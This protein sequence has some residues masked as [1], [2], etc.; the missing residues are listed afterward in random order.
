MKETSTTT[1]KYWDF[2]LVNRVNQLFSHEHF[3]ALR[4]TGRDESEAGFYGSQ[5]AQRLNEEY[6]DILKSPESSIYELGLDWCQVH[7]FTSYSVGFLF[8]RYAF[9][10]NRQIQKRLSKLHLRLP[11]LPVLTPCCIQVQGPSSLRSEQIEVPQAIGHNSR[12]ER[13]KI[14]G[15]L[16]AEDNAHICKAWTCH[17]WSSAA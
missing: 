1:Q 4:G 14:P 6:A 13:T 9:L 8:L 17:R 15:A 10:T 2:G 12:S 7:N 5:E 3:C 16:S 11:L